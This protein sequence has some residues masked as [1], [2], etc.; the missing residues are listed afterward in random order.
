[1]AKKSRSTFKK[2]QRE[3]AR[4]QKR[5]DKLARRLERRDRRAETIPQAGEED[6]DLAGARP[7]PQ[8]LSTDWQDIPDRKPPEKTPE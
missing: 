7:G 2:R 4:Q 5:Q 8:P 3:I 6:P 1:M